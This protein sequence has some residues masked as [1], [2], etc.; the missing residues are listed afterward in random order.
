MVRTMGSWAVAAVYTGWSLWYSFL[1][2]ILC[3]VVVV[4]LGSIHGDCSL[5]VASSIAAVD[6]RSTVQRHW[7][8]GGGVVLEK[9]PLSTAVWPLTLGTLPGEGFSEGQHLNQEQSFRE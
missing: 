1:K 3:V 6:G 5:D 8:G 7:L 9:R 4:V 2:F